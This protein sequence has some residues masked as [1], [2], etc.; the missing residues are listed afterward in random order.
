M[1]CPRH[2]DRMSIWSRLYFRGSQVEMMHFCP[3]DLFLSLQKVQILLKC[4][5]FAAFHLGLQC[6]PKYMFAGIQ[7]ERG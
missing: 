2:V 3:E 1:D 5:I 6:L 4:R 7:N